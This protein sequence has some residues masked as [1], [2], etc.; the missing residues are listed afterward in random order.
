MSFGFGVANLFIPLE[1]R[2]E[3]ESIS[4]HSTEMQVIVRDN[5]TCRARLHTD[6][7]IPIINSEL[8]CI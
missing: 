3:S 5:V 2:L 6:H 4:S 8:G 7:K 1:T